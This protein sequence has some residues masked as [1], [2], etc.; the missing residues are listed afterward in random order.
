MVVGADGV[1]HVWVE[2][3]HSRP[4]IT[5]FGSV[6]VRR[7]AY[8]AKGAANL[9]PVD[10]ALNLPEESFS[11]GLRAAAAVEAARG[12]FDEAVASIDRFHRCPRREASSRRPSPGRPQS[13]STRSSTPTAPSAATKNTAMGHSAPGPGTV[14][15][16]WGA[17]GRAP[18]TP[19]RRARGPPRPTP[20]ARPRAP[21]RPGGDGPPHPRKRDPSRGTASDDD[22]MVISVDG[23]GIVM[24]PEALR[25]ATAAKAACR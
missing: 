14:R 7:L 24:R 10:G 12:S 23:K 2:T 15:W 11:H 17:G 5:L 6:R 22:V 25:P 13:T 18:P 4:L 21:A 8:R 9:Y 19:R 20:R 3:G 16:G 1:R